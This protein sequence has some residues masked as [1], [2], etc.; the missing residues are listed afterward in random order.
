[1]SPPHLAA[2]AVVACLGLGLG[3]LAVWHARSGAARMAGV[4]LA[5]ALVGAAYAGGER[6]LGNARPVAFDIVGQDGDARVLYAQARRDQGIF[7]LLHAD[8]AP[9]YY[10]L[11]W[12]EQRAQELR[13]ALQDAERQQTGI[14]FRREPSLDRNERMFYPEPQPAMPDK[15]AEPPVEYRQPEWRT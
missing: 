4:A 10:R 11:P 2:W 15:G 6:V 14:L 7:L 13:A 8:P 5:V 3:A 1:M 9:L 12:D